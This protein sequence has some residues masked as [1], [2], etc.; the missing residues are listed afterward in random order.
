VDEIVAGVIVADEIVANVI[1]VAAVWTR[2]LCLVV[3]IHRVGGERVVRLANVDVT[4]NIDR[5][6]GK[7]E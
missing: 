7:W 4:T 5:A 3:F 1:V 6:S 2:Q